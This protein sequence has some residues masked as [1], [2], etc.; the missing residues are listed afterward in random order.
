M[1]VKAK[2]RNHTATNGKTT[3][4]PISIAPRPTNPT[5]LHNNAMLLDQTKKRGYRVRE[6]QKPNK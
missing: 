3:Q 2:R 5:T 1:Q 6:N 4:K